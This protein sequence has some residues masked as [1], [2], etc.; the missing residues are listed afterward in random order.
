MKLPL[1]F[2]HGAFAGPW[3]MEPFAGYFAERGWECHVP[4]LRYHDTA[5]GEEPP[6]GLVD[7][8]ID[9]YVDDLAAFVSKLDQKPVVF[10][11]AVSGIIAQRLAAMG[12]ASGVV[13]INSN[14]PWG[15]LPFTDGQRAVA[16]SLMEAGPFW[17]Q[18]MRVEFDLMA[19]FALN[20][21]PP[22]K[23]HEVFDRLGAESGRVMF[24]MFFWMFDD[25]KA[26]AVDHGSVGC[27]VLVLAGQEDKA[28]PAIAGREIAKLYGEQ[29]TFLEIANHAHFMFLEPGWEK[30]AS[31]CAEWLSNTVQM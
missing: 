15:M 27:P 30:I 7:T 5:P 9:D 28:V 20:K 6:A 26:V 1:V 8:G 3:C 4:A 11:H 17:K 2:L 21:L 23:Q 31:Q 24:E 29:A 16:K 22:A 18:P 10:G 19:G 13:L 12:L 14:V 25:R